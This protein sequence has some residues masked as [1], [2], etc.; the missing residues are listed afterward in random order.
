MYTR[1]L[2]LRFPPEITD[3]PLVYYLCK[4]Y[5]LC[6]NILKATILPGQE[7]I[8]VIELCGHKKKMSEG[9]KY[10]RSRGVEIKS[11]A[12]EIRWNRE[13]CIQCGACT[14]VC[15]KGAL[16]IERPSMEVHFDP[17]KCSGCEICV[18]VCPVRAIEIRLNKQY[19]S[20]L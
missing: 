2:I 1:I 18:M 11:L 15:P 14:G 7:G 16:Y 13:K 3:Q 5:D 19:Y 4:D 10:L 9:L 8:M 6:F 12:Q 20:S 17:S